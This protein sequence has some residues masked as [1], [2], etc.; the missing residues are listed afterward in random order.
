MAKLK[1]GICGSTKNIFT[2]LSDFGDVTKCQYHWDVAN[3]GVKMN[4]INRQKIH[5]LEKKYN[6]LYA[7]LIHDEIFSQAWCWA[8]LNLA[9]KVSNKILKLFIQLLKKEDNWHKI[10]KYL[11]VQKEMGWVK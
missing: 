11:N 3:E 10:S 2:D 8:D 1:C 9:E 4:E 6:E 5:E 7:T